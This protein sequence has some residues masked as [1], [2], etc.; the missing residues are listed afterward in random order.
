MI[1]LT[2]LFFLKSIFSKK[3]YNQKTIQ[4]FAYEIIVYIDL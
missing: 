2:K 1:D 4:C 3:C